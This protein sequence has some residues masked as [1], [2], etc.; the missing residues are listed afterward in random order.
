MFICI[1]MLVYVEKKIAYSDQSKF[2]LL[3]LDHVAGDRIGYKLLIL[4]VILCL[5]V[6]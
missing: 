6:G 2:L 4:E 1:D 5:S 3:C